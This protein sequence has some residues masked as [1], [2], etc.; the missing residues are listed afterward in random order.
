VVNVCVSFGPEPDSDSS[1]R[2]KRCRNRTVV[3]QR[4]SACG[5]EP[6]SE[7]VRLWEDVGE[8]SGRRII[9]MAAHACRDDPNSYSAVIKL[10]SV[11]F[12]SPNITNYKFPSEG[13][14]ICT[15]TTS[16]T[17]DLMWDQEILPRNRRSNVIIQVHIT[18]GGS[19]SPLNH[20]Y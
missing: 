12:V 5:R 19:W 11:Y 1:S 14:T 15:H 2:A 8:A 20:D 17:F 16:L 10:N 9:F 4:N 13:F 6:F 3:T 7:F 18:L